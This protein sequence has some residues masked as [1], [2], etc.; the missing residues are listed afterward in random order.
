MDKYHDELTVEEA[1][2]E[3]YRLEALFESC[4]RG[5][6]G[7]STKDSVRH[8][9]CK[10]MVDLYDKFK[11]EPVDYQTQ[12]GGVLGYMSSVRRL[13]TGREA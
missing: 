8:R 11:I 3:Y 1:R 13:F 6:H 4:A 2:D 5:G 7:V 9:A 12:E 10:A